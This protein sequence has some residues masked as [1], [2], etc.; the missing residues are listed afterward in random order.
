MATTAHKPAPAIPVAYASAPSDDPSSYDIELGD[1]VRGNTNVGL[2][3]ANAQKMVH[4]GFIRKV[5]G[6]LSFQ[7]LLTALISY[8]CTLGDRQTFVNL[9]VYWQWP[10]LI[11]NLALL[12]VTYAVRKKSPL[13]LLMLTVWTSTMSVSMG[14]V[15]AAFV[16]EGNTDLLFEAAAI[17]GAAFVSLTVFTFQSK[18]DFSF[19]RAGL[20]MSL[21]MVLFFSILS[22]VIGFTMPL[23]ASFIGALLFSSYIIY[24]TSRLIQRFEPDEYIDAAIQLYLDILNLFLYI[25]RILSKLKGKK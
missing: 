12:A 19:M 25:L 4:V 5:Y 15:T 6:I 13:N 23:L 21:N 24:D 22:I 10:L 1:V 7:L 3:G 11:A 2:S 17:T 18:I 9:Y 14:A 20:Y 16:E 8:A